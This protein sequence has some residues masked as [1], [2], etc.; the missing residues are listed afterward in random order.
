VIVNSRRFG[1]LNLPASSLV[2]LPDGLPGVPGTSFALVEAE[3]PFQWLQ[4]TEDP[5]VALPVTD[6]WTHFDGFRLV[7]MDADAAGL[8]LTPGQRDAAALVVVRAEG[9]PSAWTANLRAPVVVYEGRGRQVL[10]EAPLAPVR[11][12]LYPSAADLAA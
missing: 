6:P 1:V 2:E 3:G 9:P 12:P 11:A 10:N 5:G 4:S 7:I 8:G